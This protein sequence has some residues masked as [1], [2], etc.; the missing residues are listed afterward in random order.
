MKEKFFYYVDLISELCGFD[1]SEGGLVFGWIMVILAALIVIAAFY[2]WITR[3]LWPGE[4]NDDH[5]K[6]RIL[7]DVEE[8]VPHAH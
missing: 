2:I 8:E 6:R 5:I 4:E 7:L 1:G 3:S